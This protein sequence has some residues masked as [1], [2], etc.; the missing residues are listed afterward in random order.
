MVKN[1]IV[2]Y[3]PNLGKN[4]QGRIT[5]RYR[6]RGNKRKF[7]KV[8]FNRSKLVWVQKQVAGFLY[9]PNRKAFLIGVTNLKPGSNRSEITL[10]LSPYRVRKI[11]FIYNLQNLET[12][13]PFYF[14]VGAYGKLR[15]FP[16]GTFVH[17]LELEPIGSIK[18]CRAAG[19]AAQILEQ[20]VILGKTMLRLPSGKVIMLCNN[21]GGVLGNVGNKYGVKKIQKA[22]IKRWLGYRPRVRG[23]AINPVDHPH[24]GGEGKG[25]TKR[26]GIN[27][28][29]TVVKGVRFVK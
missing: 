13:N 16:V 22:G 15:N 18:F 1:L 8:L 5:I 12:I 20:F 6:C 25:S 24:G 27:P 23:V 10:L 4:N 9:D 29:G 19:S 14:Q 17:C 21:C 2:G 11:D 28:W 7:R 3:I 26:G